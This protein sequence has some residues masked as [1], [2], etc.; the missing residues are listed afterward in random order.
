LGQ[1]NQLADADLV[2]EVTQW[3][4]NH[5]LR[6]RSYLYVRLNFDSDIYPNGVPNITA[7]VQG[8]AVFDPRDSSTS[9]SNNPA[10]CI[11][12]FLTNTDYGMK[13]DVSEINDTNFSA[14]ANTCEESVPLTV[15]SE[16]RF[17][18]NG[19]FQVDQTPKSILQNMLSS[20]G[21]HVVYSNGQFKLVA[22]TFKT[23]TVTLDESKLRSGLTVNTRVSKKNY[24][25]Q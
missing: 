19:S 11:R 20:I 8:K 18:L 3:T 6:G 16:N 24:L 17:T 7:E 22:A 12:D 14:V 1:T 5:R 13:A 15:G 21:G 10:L 2:S 4:T 9:F 23:A 25:M